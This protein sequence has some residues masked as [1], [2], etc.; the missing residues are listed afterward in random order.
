MSRPKM[1]VTPAS[2]GVR[3]EAG[4]STARPRRDGLNRQRWHAP[5][6]LAAAIALVAIVASPS[7]T[8]LGIVIACYAIA[9]IGLSVLAGTTRIVNLGVSAFFGL[10]AFVT[11]SLI[12]VVELPIALVAA[13]VASMLLGLVLS[14]V[15]GR[16]T[17]VFMAILTVGVALLAQHVFRILPGWTGGTAGRTVEDP[18]VAGI[19]VTEDIIVSGTT[20]PGETVYFLVC[21]VLLVL[22]AVAT[23]NLLR[24]RSGRA[25]STLAASPVTARSFGISP[26]RYRSMAFLY[27]SALAGIAGGLFAGYSGFVSYEQF[28]VEL[29]IQLL[30]VVVLGG[31]GSV[32][33]I[34]V[35][36][37][38]LV[39]L[40]E[41]VLSLRGWLPFVAGSGSTEGFTADQFSAVLY[42]LALAVVM[43]AEPRGLTGLWH[44]F[45]TS[46]AA[47]AIPHLARRSSP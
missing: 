16:L 17:G 20:V 8:R 22:T 41:V 19:R 33:G 1:A 34:V 32:Y 11:A 10:G 13:A 40:P 30:A 35:A 4:S 28:S 21:A 42:G 38:I 37:V 47:R 36:A 44:R 45:H 25:L 26:A 12:P 23:T 46:R 15:A 5:L 27:S 24:S 6:I 7:Q 2:A 3:P 18:V 31:L 29:S 9:G 43:V 14:P 39:G